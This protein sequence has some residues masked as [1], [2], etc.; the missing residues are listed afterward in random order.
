MVKFSFNI[1]N[2]DNKARAGIIKTKHGEIKTPVFMP[3]GTSATVKAI[4]Q[5]TYSTLILKLF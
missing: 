5:K 4:F 3:V 2:N 1:E